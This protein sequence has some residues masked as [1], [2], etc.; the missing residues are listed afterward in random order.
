VVDIVLDYL[1]IGIDPARSTIFVHSA[2]PALNQLLLPFLSVVSMSELHR[3]PTVKD[4]IAHSGRGSV[5]GLM[6][7]YP[8]HQ[9]ADILFCHGNLVPGGRDQLPHLEVTRDVARRINRLYFEEPYFP[10]PE[11]LMGEV[12]LLLGLD[13]QKMGKSMGNAIYLHMSADETARLIKGA[14]T[15]SDRHITFDPEHRPEVSNLVQIITLCEGSDPHVVAEEIGD[16]GAVELKRR[17]TEAL[18]EHF[19]PIRRSRLELAAD[20]AQ[21][22]R[23]L[24]EGCERAEAIAERTLDELREAMGMKYF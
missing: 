10:E 22:W 16:G 18:N 17:L 21:V 1:G 24:R 7:T 23:T 15:D 12:P 20:P 6:M 19:A 14:K 2:I 13:G 11:L 4:E 8:V 5:S 3:N 9:A